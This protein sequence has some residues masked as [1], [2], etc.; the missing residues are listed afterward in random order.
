MGIARYVALDEIRKRQR[1]RK[2]HVEE[3]HAHD[4]P[5]AHTDADLALQ[6]KDDLAALQRGLARLPAGQRA[7]LLSFHVDGESY[8]RI[9]KRHGVPLGTVATWICRARRALAEARESVPAPPDA[10]DP[11]TRGQS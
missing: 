11:A 2:H 5:A 6:R 8:E 3:H 9:A 7:A 1:E 4:T 10:I